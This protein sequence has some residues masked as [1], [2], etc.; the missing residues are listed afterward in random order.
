M[1]KTKPQTNEIPIPNKPTKK[2]YVA[3]KDHSDQADLQIIDLQKEN[4]ELFEK[5]ED[6]EYELENQEIP[7][8]IVP[9]G[10]TK[11]LDW[12]ELHV[13]V[14]PM[15]QPKS[16]ADGKTFEQ[17]VLLTRRPF[18]EEFQFKELRLF[19]DDGIDIVGQAGSAWFVHLSTISGSIPM[20]LS[21]YTDA[22]AEEFL[23]VAV[24]ADTIKS[25]RELIMERLIYQQIHFN[26][27]YVDII[28]QKEFQ[29]QAER[30]HKEK[31]IRTNMARTELAKGNPDQEA[32]YAGT[33]HLYP[34]QIGIIGLG[35]FV[36]FI[37]AFFV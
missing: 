4:L 35:W 1:S 32:Q 21:T 17:V 19:L 33:Y 18:E 9:V 12:K 10:K 26:A 6:L 15:D 29:Y 16:F 31:I 5:I 11:L 20:I 8:V 28:D 34:L 30:T 27:S 7:I 37:L 2:Q 22:D 25:L 36:A 13:Q 3:L 23:D 14:I 24:T